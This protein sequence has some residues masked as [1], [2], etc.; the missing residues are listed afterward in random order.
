V[1]YLLPVGAPVT[2]VVPS[3]PSAQAAALPPGQLPPG[4]VPR[5]E[6][7]MRFESAPARYKVGQMLKTYGTG[8]WSVSGEVTV[9]TGATQQTYKA[10]EA[11]IETPGRA[12]LSGNTGSTPAV[13][14]LSTTMPQD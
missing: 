11:W 6:S 9:L 1:T 14:A 3:D 2:T 5:F 4:A 12:W 7:R 10:G 13:V 8:V